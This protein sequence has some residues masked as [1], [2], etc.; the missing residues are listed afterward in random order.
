MRV[1]S[2]RWVVAFSMLASQILTSQILVSPAFAST[3]LDRVR[4][5]KVFKLGYRAD[6]KPYSYRTDRGEPA[7]YI[8]DLCREVAADVSRA[9]GG[10]ITV[11]YVVVPA[12]QRFDAIK[13]GRIDV[14]CDP[15][16]IT[17][18]RREIVD[19]SL[20]TYLDGA[21]ILSR[22]NK[23]VETYRDLDRKRVDVL[24]GTTTQRTL[25]QSLADLQVKAEIVTVTDHRA[26]MD[27]LAGDKIDAYFADRGII[28]AILN[29]GGRPGFRLASRYF[30]YETYG[31]ALRRG[32]SE[33]R[34]L[35]DR[36]L[37]RLYR[38]GRIDQ[39]LARTFGKAPADEI[40]KA[41]FIINSMPD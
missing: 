27:L 33:F 30:S 38:T 31:L 34:L 29:E 1:R 25:Q 3:T 13:D 22:T 15:A 10:G 9:A 21:S 20:P 8:V 11:E 26:G 36:T 32:D 17:M 16:S 12:N 18:A 35:V 19:F 23:P 2:V 7:G 40:L 6:A 4:E 39:I 41:M 24:V 5:T 14:L 28:A 37:S